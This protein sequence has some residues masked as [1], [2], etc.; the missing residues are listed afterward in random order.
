M[1]RPNAPM[2]H[3]K[4]PKILTEKEEAAKSRK[5]RKKEEKLLKLQRQSA[6]IHKYRVSECLV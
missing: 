3:T 5:Q 4:R 2:K 1:A 6:K